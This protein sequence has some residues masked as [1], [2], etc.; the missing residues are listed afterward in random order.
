MRTTKKRM[1]RKGESLCRWLSAGGRSWRRGRGSRDLSGL[2]QRETGRWRRF[3]RQEEV[4]SLSS[5]SVEDDGAFL[6]LG[7]LSGGDT[8][9]RARAC[10]LVSAKGRGQSTS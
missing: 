2:G 10:L 9:V 3:G 7:C 6:C 1:K 5:F 8:C 4:S